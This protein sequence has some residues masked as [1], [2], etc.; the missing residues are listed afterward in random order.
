M[1]E[2][3]AN[4]IDRR[5]LLKGA[6][7]AGV[8]SAVLGPVA[9]AQDGPVVKNG[10]INQSLAFWCYESYWSVEEMCRV[11]K[12]LGCTSIELAQVEDWP[13]LEKHGLTCALAHSHWFDQGMNNPKYQPMCLQKMR[14]SIDACA[15][16]GFP[17]V[18]TFTGFREDISDEDG[19]RNCISGYKE[20]VGYAEAKGVTLCLEMLNS[21]DE[22]EM[23]GH[24]GYQGDHT[25]YVME[26]IKGV[27]SPALKLLFDVYHVQIMDGD[28]IRRIDEY[29]E[30]IGHYH[31]AGNPGRNEIGGDQ[32]INYA[33]IMEKIVSTGY[34]GYVGQEFLPTRDPFES[35]KEA[36]TICDV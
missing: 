21:R 14:D 24:P 26:I 22:T 6:V 33:P 23:K 8:A 34:T 27:S 7:A 30:Y 31:T 16:H 1:S 36:V 18:I 15:A 35:L 4:A 32:E 25:D 13:V 19:I 9:E 2:H 5:S 29:A 28:I 17:N 11:A 20:I 12:R 3:R 10:R